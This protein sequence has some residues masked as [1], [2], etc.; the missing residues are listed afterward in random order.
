MG[1]DFPADHAARMGR[2]FGL[3]VSAILHGDYLFVDGIF[4]ALVLHVNIRREISV[5]KIFPVLIDPEPRHGVFQLGQVFNTP[6]KGSSFRPKYS[7]NVDQK[8]FDMSIVIMKKNVRC[9]KGIV[10]KGGD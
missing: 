8:K 9:L 5:H 7:R 10:V 2:F 1:I 6:T 4:P 3:T